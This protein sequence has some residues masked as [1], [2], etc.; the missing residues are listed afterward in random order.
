[1]RWVAPQ[2]QPQQMTPADLRGFLATMV[3]NWG[4]RPGTQRGLASM[5]G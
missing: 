1:M 2:G 4:G 3:E 5:K